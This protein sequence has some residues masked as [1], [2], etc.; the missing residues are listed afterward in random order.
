MKKA[1]MAVMAVAFLAAFTSMSWAQVQSTPVV[2]KHKRAHTR[3][4]Y[5]GPKKAV[6]PSKV[7]PRFM[8]KNRGHQNAAKTPTASG[9]IIVR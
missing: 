7:H 6:D 3:P 9:Q 8:P 1:I 4:P 2:P 5:S